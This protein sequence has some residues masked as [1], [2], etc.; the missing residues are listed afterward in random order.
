MCEDIENLATEVENMRQTHE[1][2]KDYT[3]LE[4]AKDKT[5]FVEMRDSLAQSVRGLV[6]SNTFLISD[7]EQVLENK[8][9][10]V[11]VRDI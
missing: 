7:R 11:K 9:L 1:E 5:G 4:L 3:R 2:R 10:C 6:A 8:P